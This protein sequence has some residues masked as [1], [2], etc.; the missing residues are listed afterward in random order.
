MSAVGKRDDDA[1]ML[2]STLVTLDGHAGLT[3]LN[4]MANFVQVSNSLTP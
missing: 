2:K 4:Q 1:D 3:L